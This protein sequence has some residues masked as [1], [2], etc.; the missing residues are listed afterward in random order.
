MSSEAGGAIILVGAGNMGGAL[1]ARWL[2]GGIRGSSITVIE[3]APSPTLLAK[4][5]DAGARHVS[6]VPDGAE[7]SILFLAIKPQSMHE[8]LPN[9]A[10]MVTGDTVAVSVAA[11]KTTAFIK[12]HLGAKAVVRAMPNMPAMIGRGITGAYASPAV[13]ANPARPGERP[14]ESCRPCRMA[15]Q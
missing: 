3:P 1:L 11:G 13:T 14:F 10:P 8:V 2:S 6:S 4:I 7:A 15:G 12:A 9:L 5:S